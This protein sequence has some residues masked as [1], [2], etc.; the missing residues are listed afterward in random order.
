[1]SPLTT[2]L[3]IFQLEYFDLNFASSDWRS[4]MCAKIAQ[5]RTV[6]KAEALGISF[7]CSKTLELLHLMN[8]VWSK[9]AHLLL[10]FTS[11]PAIGICCRFVPLGDDL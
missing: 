6:G 9:L 7:G 8:G 4:L 2:A 10:S 3:A 5:M 1:M 11:L